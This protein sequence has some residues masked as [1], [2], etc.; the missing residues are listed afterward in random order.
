MEIIKEVNGTELT[1]KIT[2]RIDTKTSVQLSEEVNA[3]L[4]GMTKLVFDLSGVIYLSSA[5]LRVFV[6]TGDRMQKQGLMTIV[7]V[8][9]DLMEI[10]KITG[11]TDI[12]DI[13]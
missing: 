2:G 6:T 12:L 1:L 7:G 4:E 13:R 10:F 11:L 3:N 8:N 5:G 9:D